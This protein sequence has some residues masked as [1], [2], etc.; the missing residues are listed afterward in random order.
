MV[1]TD[2]LRN[3]LN[4]LMMNNFVIPE[5]EPQYLYHYTDLD[6]AKSIIESGQ[7]WV[8]DAFTTTDEKEIIHVKDIIN[9]I[10][11]A[12]YSFLENENMKQ[13][14]DFLQYAID[15]V[16]TK[17]FILCF[18]LVK[19]SK[20]LWEKYSDNN[21]IGVCLRFDFKNITPNP[22]SDLFSRERYFVEHNGKDIKI[23][24][25]VPN[26]FIIYNESIKYKK[27]EEYMNLVYKVIN[28][29][30]INNFDEEL[31]K[32]EI[33]LLVDIFTDTL[34]FSSFSKVS[35]LKDEKEYRML[36]L[37][38]KDSK[39]QLILKT[40]MKEN[41]NIRYVT[42]NMKANNT[43]SLNRIFVSNK[44][45]IREVKKELNPFIGIDIKI[46]SI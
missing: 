19:D 40:R 22:V 1:N 39:F 29:I 41:K 33:N 23:Q 36:Y 25:L 10:I 44:K 32:D 11:N 18:S 3:E 17:V 45:D 14:S 38:K 4:E 5:R 21:K 9:R 46:K 28:R 12:K 27:I 6:S 34:L 15:I 26:H 35:K 7:F 8:S 42:T 16:K 13:C 30:P 37:F 43:F 20:P 2:E 24:L 31:Y